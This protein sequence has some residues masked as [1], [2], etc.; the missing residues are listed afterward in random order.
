MIG[1]FC[2]A[3]LAGCGGGKSLP[4]TVPELSSAVSAGVDARAAAITHVVVI[5][6][7]NR[8][9]DDL[10]G[11]F[12]GGPAAYPGGDGTVPSSIAVDIKPGGFDTKPA[13]NA[14]DWYR[15]L[16]VNSFSAETWRD[17]KDG[18]WP[19]SPV[20]CP[21][22]APPAN[23]YAHRFDDASALTIID[24]TH[25]ATYVRL[26]Q[27]FEISD[28]Y[29]AV[30]DADS[31]SGH[32]FIVAL[33]SHNDLHQLI[34]GTP[35]RSGHSLDCGSVI[36]EDDV[37]T[38][39]L[40]RVSG[41]TDWRFEGRSAACWNYVTFADRL[42]SRRI[43]WRHYSTDSG[44]V[45]NGFINFSSWYPKTRPDVPGS[46]FRIVLDH[47]QK[48]IASGDLPQF[49]WIKPPCVALSD[50]PGLTHD[51]YGGSDWVASVVNWIG[52][53][54][55]LWPHT[56]IFVVWDD[57]GGFYDHRT[58]RPPGLG[59]DDAL[60]PGMRQP[61]IA[62]SAYDK[63]PA[64]VRHDY[65]TYASVLRFAEDLYGVP[66]LNFL[67]AT[68]PPLHEYFDF[69]KPPRPFTPIAYSERGFDAHA[70]CKTYVGIQPYD[71]DR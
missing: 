59:F 60:T 58:P 38:P 19:H 66:P 43:T 5:S 30:Q 29:Y 53:N 7:E 16:Q 63:W 49:T 45:F 22:S 20:S 69:H 25:R 11:G 6:Q 68:A 37:N 61:F 35:R 65:A 46:H 8:T 55:A 14:H 48:D 23:P 57:W 33:G 4:S 1:L 32:Q 36:S 31:F 70:A 71:V 13:Y 27:E 34:S 3:A 2:L 9:Y 12:A 41:F 18:V 42:E 26:A 21:T 62:I 28:N 52:S 40:D 51:P 10:F 17:L 54:P 47:L 67:D 44:G 56:V 64:A 15:C 50:H 24:D 39:I